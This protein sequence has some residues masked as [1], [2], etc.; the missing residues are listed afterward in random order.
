MLGGCVGEYREGECTFV[1]LILCMGT[2]RQYEY[3]TLYVCSTAL[4]TIVYCRFVYIQN[5][6]LVFEHVS[7]FFR[8]LFDFERQQLV[9]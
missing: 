5:R 3:S 1:Y 7:S 4:I 6:I 9:R 2:R 8:N